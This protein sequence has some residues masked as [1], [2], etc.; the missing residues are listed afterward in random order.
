MELASVP[1]GLIV[2]VAQTV[3][4]PDVTL[5]VSN[6]VLSAAR[7]SRMFPVP[8]CTVSLNVTTR[9]AATATPVASSAGL[10]AVTVGGV[11]S[12]VRRR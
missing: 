6:T 9:F 7:R 1:A 11:V 3:T 10:N 12:A 8:F 5:I 4:R 2:T